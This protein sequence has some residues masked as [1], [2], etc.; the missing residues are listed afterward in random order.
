MKL[1]SQSKTPLPPVFYLKDGNPSV[2]NV[3]EV[4]GSLKGVD[5][6]ARAVGVVLVP[7]DAGGVVSGVVGVHVQAALQA[8]LFEQLG[9]RAAVP[10]AVV[11]RL[12]ADERV[13]V[14]VFRLVVIGQSK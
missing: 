2:A 1:L 14:V 7:V 6:T 4:N 8:T 11:S 10:H 13:L 3:V 5:G 12:G 9:H